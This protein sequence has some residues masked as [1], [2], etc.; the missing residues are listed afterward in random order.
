MIYRYV[1]DEV[2]LTWRRAPGAASRAI[3]LVLAATAAV[4]RDAESYRRD[5]GAVPKMRAALHAGPVIAGEIGDLKREIAFLGDTLNTASRIAETARQHEGLLLASVAA[6]DG[7]TLPPG[8]V[9][10]DLGPA[11]LRGRAEPVALALVAAAPGIDAS[12]S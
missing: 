9:R 10:R 7:V 2:I 12:P 1:G 8:L 4:A 5:F 3:A 6:L 11:A